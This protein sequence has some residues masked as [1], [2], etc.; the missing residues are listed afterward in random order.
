MMNKKRKGRRAQGQKEQT[1][2]LDSASETTSQY[3]AVQLNL[4]GSC[5]ADGSRGSTAIL[6]VCTYNVRTLRTEDDLHRLID[7]VEQI[8][9]DIIG[10]CETCRKREGLSE[11]R[12]GYWV[13]EIGKT[14]DNLS[15]K[16]PAFLIHPKI[17]ECAIDF[18]TYSNRVIKM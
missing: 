6:N 9:R 5:T 15:A 10:L 12:G 14:E 3:D 13:Y 4:K 2:K 18:K 1:A 17:K 11:I 16:G 8:K 7:E